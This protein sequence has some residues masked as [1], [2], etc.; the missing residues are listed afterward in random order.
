MTNKFQTK[1]PVIS[2]LALT[3]ILSPAAFAE[4]GSGVTGYAAAGVIMTPEYEGSDD[5]QA[6]PLISARANYEQ[7]YIETN[8]L[9]VRANVLPMKSIEFGPVLSYTMGRDDD[10]ENERV[11]RMREI[12]AGASAGA[13][14]RVPF[15][16]VMDETD[17]LAFE[18]QATTDV[19]SVSDGTVFTFGPSYSF[20]PSQ[21][22]R[23]GVSASA[24]Y[25]TDDYNQTYFGVDA[26]NAARSGLAAYKAEGGIKDVGL[27]VNAN[28]ALN[29][30][31]GITGIAGYKQLIGDAADSPV[32]DKEGNAGQVMVGAGISYSF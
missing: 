32:V 22:L 2:F 3:I 13:F 25:T 31:W 14:V 18:I 12:D 23:L 7:Y 5:L 19:S 29:E 10:V 26:D 20:S 8:G 30:Q 21:D 9:G 16:S 4:S 24:A 11:K 17:E 1:I 6:A 28:F 15:H 27:M